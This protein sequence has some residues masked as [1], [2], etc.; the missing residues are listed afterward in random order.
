MAI[1]KELA[2]GRWFKFSLAEQLANVGSEIETGVP[3]INKR[4]DLA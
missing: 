3:Q 2:S 1:H 4:F